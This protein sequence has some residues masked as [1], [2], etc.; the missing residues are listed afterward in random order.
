MRPSWR[1]HAFADPVVS[2]RRDLVRLRHDPFL[3]P[4]TRVRGFE[5]YESC[6]TRNDTES[7]FSSVNWLQS[8]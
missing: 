1:T 2:V 5:L 8:T 4:D 3:L 6:P 7:H